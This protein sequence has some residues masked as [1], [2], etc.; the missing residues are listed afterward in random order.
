MTYLCKK[1][2][3]GREYWYRQRSYR[4]GKKVKTEST[5]LGPAHTTSPGGTSDINPYAP[6]DKFEYAERAG[7]ITD[8][9]EVAG[10]P[11]ISEAVEA[12]TE[13]ASEAAPSES[14]GENAAE[15]STSD[16]K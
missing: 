8:Q 11:A 1:V 12:P 14:A 3:R 15:G 16:G 6:D 2:I 10:P 13:A 9:F 5:Y 7:M 4:V